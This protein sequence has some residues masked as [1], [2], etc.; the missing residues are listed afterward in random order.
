MHAVGTGG[1]GNINPVVYYAKDVRVPA[2]LRKFNSECKELVI[3]YVLCPKLDA[4]GTP[5]HAAMRQRNNI[6]SQVAGDYHIQL[7]SSEFLSRVAKKNNILLKC[8][9]RISQVFHRISN[10]RIHR[11][12]CLCERPQRLS[13]ALAGRG[14]AIFQLGTPELITERPAYA[15]IANSIPARDKPTGVEFPNRGR[16]PVTKLTGPLRQRGR[17]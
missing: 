14:K 4:I 9:S 12:C 8:V 17:I 6:S 16:K 3:V 1:N 5:G 10:G 13:K 7:N 15:N 2:Y 11:S